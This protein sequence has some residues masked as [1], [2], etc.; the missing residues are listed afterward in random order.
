MVWFDC[1]CGETLKKPSVPNHLA[2]K[3]CRTLI[4]ADCNKSFDRESYDSHRKCISEAQKYQ[5]GLYQAT[6]KQEGA[7]QDRWLSSLT[8]I[9][10][11]YSG[12]LKP[13]LNKLLSFE[14]VPRKQKPFLAFCANSLRETGARAAAI[15]E[16]IK[17]RVFTTWEQEL[18]IILKE[19]GGRMHWRLLRDTAVERLGELLPQIPPVKIGLNALAHV[20][21]E[22]LKD[23]KSVFVSL[24]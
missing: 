8:E 12:P 14:N 17:P 19:H 23:D 16:L 9:A 4:C 7:K 13:A 5:K 6:A 11:S 24:A 3:S 15:W 22:W 20:K 10:A 1:D 2:I 18:E 21:K